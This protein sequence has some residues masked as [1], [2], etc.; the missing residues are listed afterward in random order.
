MESRDTPCEKKNRYLKIQKLKMFNRRPLRDINKTNTLKPRLKLTRLR[1]VSDLDLNI[2]AMRWYRLTHSQRFDSIMTLFFCRFR[3]D[4][5]FEQYDVW[6]LYASSIPKIYLK[7]SFI[8]EI[9]FHGSREANEKFQN[10]CLCS[11]KF[12]Q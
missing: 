3:R 11:S 5:V 9:C 6:T 8:Y 7:I 2:T 12:Y 1:K 10:K 4:F